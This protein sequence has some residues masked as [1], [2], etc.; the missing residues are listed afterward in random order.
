MDSDVLAKFL[1]KSNQRK[2]SSQHEY[3]DDNKPMFVPIQSPPFSRI[4]VNNPPAYDEYRPPVDLDS[5]S[6][7]LFFRFE[8]T[9]LRDDIFKTLTF[10]LVVLVLIPV[11]LRLKTRLQSKGMP[12]NCRR[13]LQ[14]FLTF[15][16]VC[17]IVGCVSLLILSAHIFLSESNFKKVERLEKI[18]PWYVAT[19]IACCVIEMIESIFGFADPVENSCCRNQRVIDLHGSLPWKDTVDRNAFLAGKEKVLCNE[20]YRLIICLLYTS[21]SPRD[22]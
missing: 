5:G 20:D 6:P 1:K 2:I 15:L 12:V 9:V 22:S 4:P 3:Y 19:I 7:E 10:V 11:L 14:V 8:L 18:F 21:P 17:W 16:N 13:N